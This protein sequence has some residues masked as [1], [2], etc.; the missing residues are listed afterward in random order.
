[1][2]LVLEIVSPAG[3]RAGLES[4]AIEAASAGGLRVDV[5]HPSKWPWAKDQPVRA[6][7]SEEGGCACSLLSD[8]AEWN[9]ES[10]AM[11][12]A[13]L[14]RLGV[15]LEILGERGPAGVAPFLGPPVMTG[16]PA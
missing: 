8:A 11:R 13:V 10:W 15:T 12:P 5:N 2:C 6:T 16:V 9:A 14:E 4:A 1:M 7:I 3:T